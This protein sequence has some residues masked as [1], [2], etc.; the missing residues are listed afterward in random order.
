MA[1]RAVRQQI[2]GLVR[3]AKT[4]S[5][6]VAL[7]QLLDCPSPSPSSA[8]RP[9]QRHQLLMKRH[10]QLAAELDLT[11]DPWRRWNGVLL[12]V[13]VELPFVTV[14]VLVLSL[15]TSR[16]PSDD[17]STQLAAPEERCGWVLCSVFGA[18]DSTSVLD[19]D[20]SLPSGSVRG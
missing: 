4:T 5:F 10:S 7:V 1:I 16:R 2:D 9:G 8:L 6:A 19:S 17:E 12:F 14:T 11:P 15:L 3:S 13:I 20:G 18:I